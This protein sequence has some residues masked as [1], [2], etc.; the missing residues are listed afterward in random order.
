MVTGCCDNPE[1][2]MISYRETPLVTVFYFL[3]R[4]YNQVVIKLVFIKNVVCDMNLQ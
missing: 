1:V 3:E 4:Y 2:I